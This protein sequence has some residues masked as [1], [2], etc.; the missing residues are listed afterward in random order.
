MDTTRTDGTGDDAGAEHPNEPQP[1]GPQPGSAHPGSAHGGSSE[2]GPRVTAAE[3]RDLRRLRRSTTDKT[4]AG[5][6][7]G[8][9]RHLDVD[10]T[11]LRVAFAVLAFFGGSGLLLY[12]AAWLLVPTDDGRPATLRLD[13]RSRALALA[14]AGLVAA[15]ALV[16]DLV[17]SSF[18]VFNIPW[19]LLVVAA[20]V[21][22]LVTRKQDPA[23]RPRGSWEPV[24][25]TYQTPSYQTPAAAAGAAPAAEAGTAWSTSAP[26]PPPLTQAGPAPS[27]PLAPLAPPPVPRPDP[28][29]R[30]PLLFGPTL[31]L[32]LLA[33]GVLGM[34]DV[35][36]VD[37]P[38]SAYP[39]LGLAVTAVVLLV[40]SV[41]GRPGGVIA[42][43]LVLALAT[44]V[45]T[46]GEHV[47]APRELVAPTTAAALGN[48]Y[49][50]GIGRLEIDLGDLSPTQVDALDGRT[51]DLS[52]DVGELVVVVP[53][54]LAVDV[55]GSVE[56]AGNLDLL[57]YH[58]DGVSTDGA[59]T[60]RVYDPQGDGTGDLV[61]NRSPAASLPTTEAPLLT[62]DASVGLGRIEVTTR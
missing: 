24:P 62:I 13:D 19:G 39:A 20:V 37:V 36:G 60:R 1:G 44:A 58:Y 3:A 41:W 25:P 16:A 29:K 7:G 28:R 46:A 22:W 14:L 21:V 57:G 9:A 59:V 26:V 35:A 10:P 54:G 5:V 30:G 56:G 15:L 27:A 4:I 61:G 40:G 50:R 23:G 48:D 8:L 43:G 12:V 55:T 38:A 47:D 6:A 45:S 42:L 11:L 17:D 49:T 18:G 2:S 51:L 31:A 53:D 34:V 52:V 33:W 32:L